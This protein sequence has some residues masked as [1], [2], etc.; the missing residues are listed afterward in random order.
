MKFF[1]SRILGQW[2]ILFFLLV[3][4]S[5][6]NRLP[7]ALLKVD[8]T[9]NRYIEEGKVAGLVAYVLRDG[10]PFYTRAFGFSDKENKEPMQLD[11]I[12]RIASM[13]KAITSAAVLM[14]ADADKL[15]LEDKLSDYIPEFKN[16]QVLVHDSDTKNVTK[17]KKE[18]RLEPAKEE[19]TIHHLLT[20]SSGLSYALEAELT[21]LYREASLGPALPSNW[22]LSVL[23]ETVCETAQ[24]IAKL[25]L[26]V[27]P[28]SGFRYG[29]ST[30]VLGCVIEKVSEMPLDKFFEEKI[31][32][33]LGMTDTYFFLP[34]EK[35]SRLTTLY[36]SD[37]NGL[38]TRALGSKAYPYAEGYRKNFSGGAGLVSTAADYARFLEMIRQGGKIGGKR[39]L[40]EKTVKQMT[41]SPFGAR[42]PMPASFTYGF[43]IS[44]YPNANGE[45][46]VASYGWTGAYGTFYRVDP[47]QKM[48]IILM[49]QL[50]PNGTDIRD[51]FWRSLYDALAEARARY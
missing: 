17:G 25:P 11:S 29:Y 44:L 4:C 40:K 7:N 28:G 20:H 1:N 22:N 32:K 30:D 50:A 16:M 21:D 47:R 9:L 27:Q 8:L 43:D 37:K 10:I 33:P 13:T 26:A 46:A 6:A 3:G 51:T 5:R 18:I 36:R 42:A 31:F 14:L 34:K 15:R 39:Y 41:Y 49:T 2:F 35:I 24:K 23:D 38:A 45:R 12:F 19:I 48:V